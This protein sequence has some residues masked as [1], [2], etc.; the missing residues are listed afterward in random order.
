[1]EQSQLQQWTEHIS[2]TFFGR[3]FRHQI[4]FN[5]RLRACG[6]RYFPKTGNIDVS[7]QHYEAFGV[8]EL[9]GIIKHE[10]CH[11]H[12]HQQGLPYA[13]RDQ[14]FKNLLSTVGGT[15]FCRAIIK[16]EYRYQ[17]ICN[18]CARVAYRKRRIRPERYRC[19]KC[20][21]SLRLERI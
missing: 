4:M 20:H 3:P 10:L 19:G 2:I 13:H 11:Y 12:L 16:P 7:L 6:G 1:M 17:V 9:E 18:G 21:G 15:R 8:N 14:T 5:A